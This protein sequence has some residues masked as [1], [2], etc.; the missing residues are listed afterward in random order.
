M[1]DSTV[2]V[3]YFSWGGTTKSAA[4]DIAGRLGA[5]IFELVPVKPYPSDYDAATYVA[6]GEVAA[7][8]RP[9][10]AGELP[11]LSG[12]ETVI[13]AMPL[14]WAAAPRIMFTFIEAVD[15]SGKKVLT[16][17]TNRSSGLSGVDKAFRKALPNATV[18][19]GLAIYDRRLAKSVGEIVDWLTLNGLVLDEPSAVEAGL[20]S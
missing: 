1:T 11:D 9:E 19:D 7:E 18:V 3:V 20:G 16:F 2:I 4:E 5:D 10:I 12:Y 6:G 8:A 14:W 15:L 13:L 17:V